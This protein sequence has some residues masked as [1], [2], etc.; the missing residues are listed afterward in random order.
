VKAFPYAIDLHTLDNGLRVAL[1]PYD[2]PGSSPTS[3]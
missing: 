2:S 3:R 1:I